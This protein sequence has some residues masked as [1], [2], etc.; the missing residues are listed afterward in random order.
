[1]GV[2]VGGAR[3][4]RDIGFMEQPALVAPLDGSAERL[5]RTPPSDDEDATCV[6]PRTAVKA[7]H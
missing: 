5:G 7:A 1:M 3:R 6:E 2:T 4:S